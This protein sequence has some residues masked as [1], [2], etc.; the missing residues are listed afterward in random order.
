MYVPA[1]TSANLVSCLKWNIKYV[2]IVHDENSEKGKTYVC[3]KLFKWLKAYSHTPNIFHEIVVLCHVSM[4]M[5][6]R[7]FS[8]TMPGIVEGVKTFVALKCDPSDFG[9]ESEGGSVPYVGDWLARI[10]QVRLGISPTCW[11]LFGLWS[12]TREVWLSPDD[13]FDASSGM[14]TKKYFWKLHL[15]HFRST[16]FV[17]V[18]LFSLQEKFSKKKCYVKSM[19]VYK[20]SFST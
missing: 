1:L 7:I 13:R 9:S 8:W 20:H 2:C 10:C 16:I 6:Q 18:F 14:L 4:K 11:H 12:T 3:T 17:F 5:W 15:L 19:V